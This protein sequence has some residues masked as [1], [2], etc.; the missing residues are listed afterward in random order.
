MQWLKVE[1]PD[2]QTNKPPHPSLLSCWAGP[3]HLVHLTG[4]ASLYDHTAPS[5]PV[6]FDLCKR[7]TLLQMPLRSC[8]ILEVSAS[9]PPTPPRL[10]LWVLAE[11]GILPSFTSVHWWDMSTSP[12]QSRECAECR[13]TSQ[14][15]CQRDWGLQGPG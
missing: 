8:G 15:L 14:W 2:S 4:A 9:L 5:F 7:S 1:R 12:E 13:T 11:G 10:W 3:G 6:F